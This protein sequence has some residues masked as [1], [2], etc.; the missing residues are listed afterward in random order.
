[1]EH[2]QQHGRFRL[3]GQVDEARSTMR[4]LLLLAALSSTSAD[5]TATKP[6]MRPPSLRLDCTHSQ[7]V[8]IHWIASEPV[9]C[10]R[11]K[12]CL[13]LELLCVWTDARA[14]L[15]FFSGMNEKSKKQLINLVAW[16]LI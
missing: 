15:L 14:N 1:M 12:R 7:R 9:D 13:V 4:V 10:V 8:C 6:T 2:R 3:H 5:A 11:S 16:E